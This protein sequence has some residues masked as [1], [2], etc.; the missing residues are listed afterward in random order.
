MI[1]AIVHSA[2]EQH[3]FPGAVVLL[4][5]QARIL[6]LAAYGSTMY[7]DPGSQTVT[8]DTR[9]DIASLTKIITA[10]A[11]LRLWEAHQIDLDATACTYL[12]ELRATDVTIRHLLSHTSGLDVRLSL[13]ARNGREALLNAVYQAPLKQSPGSF[14][15]YTNIN[16]LLVGEIVA[17][18]WGGTLDAA[19]ADLVLTPLR[20]HAT[21]FCPPAALYPAIAPTEIDMAWRGGLIQGSVH[22]ESAHTLGGIAGHAG[23]FSTAADLQRFCQAWLT[24]GIVLQEATIQLATRNHAPAHG[25]A[26]GLG[27]ML[28]RPAFM[29]QAA[30]S[31]F[32]HTGFTGPAIVL[33]PALQ[34]LLVVLSNRT[35]PQRGASSHHAVTAALVDCAVRMVDS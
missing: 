35:Y 4:A 14:A 21:C 19:L 1:D 2:I 3:V 15:A 24:P 9:Y 26:C 18:V 11:L 27:W 8:V 12:P 22:D 28:A 20:M 31:S 16:A 13:A 34:L 33:I 5:H 10:T 25:L 17:R 29:G 7:A 23:L 30:T 32:G 6:H